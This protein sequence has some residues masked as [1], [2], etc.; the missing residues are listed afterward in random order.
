[1]MQMQIDEPE[2]P[3]AALT[4]DLEHA[5]ELSSTKE[6]PQVML[7]E[8]EALYRKLIFME[9]TSDSAT[10]LKEKAVANL[11]KM[12]AG[13]NRADGIGAL[14]KELR[15]VFATFPKAKTAKLVR[16]L[17]DAM[18][19]IPD[20]LELQ[21]ELC[22]E[23]VQWTITEKRT[24]LRQR[25]QT[26]LCELYRIQKEYTQALELLD[27]LIK[28]VKRLD[29]KNLLIEIFL[30]ETRVHYELSNIPRAKGSLTGARAC[31]NATYCPPMLQAEMD[32]LAGT[33][34]AEEND[35]KTGF[36]YF[37]EA[38][39]CHNQFG[40]EDD[41]EK[42]V[43]CLKY[44]LLCKIMLKQKD[45]VNN[46]ING[47]HAVKYQGE[48]M[49]AMAAIAGASNERSLQKF[50]QALDDFDQVLRG[51][52]FIK[53]H[54]AALYDNL[55]QENLCRIIEPYSRVEVEHIAKLIALPHAQIHK[56][57]QQ[58]IL[59]RKFRGILDQGAGCLVVFEEQ[60][61]DGIYDN[62]LSTIKNMDDVVTQLSEKA[63]KC[64]AG[65]MAPQKPAPKKVEVKK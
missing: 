4:A 11:G 37:Y 45:E 34:C 18:S 13:Q 15:P 50:E 22:K 58:M 57:L 55:L 44:M 33:L 43:L 6:P 56:K 29:D 21:V 65:D 47:K 9:D 49:E 48:N 61:K 54:L 5:D 52:S 38:F 24:F 53:S 16:V 25:L 12:Y 19:K 30:I 14:L 35:F 10:K 27:G 46:I 40:A 36:S 26:K 62:A 3:Y 60:A 2:D 7:A 20:S 41:D 64:Y 23:S 17:L 31:A 1:M 28:E 42:A 63:A 59:D 51:D 32:A 39:E 8:A